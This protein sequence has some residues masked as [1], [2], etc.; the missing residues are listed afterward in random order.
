[1]LKFSQITERMERIEKAKSS[2]DKVNSFRKF[3]DKIKELQ[4][5]FKN[6][7]GNEEPN[8]VSW[9]SFFSCTRKHS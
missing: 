4:V 2:K 1:M 3:V 5:K 9:I 6:E 8:A 7:V